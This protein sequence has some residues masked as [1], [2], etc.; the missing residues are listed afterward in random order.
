MPQALEKPEAVHFGLPLAS[1]NI[2]A[3]AMDA[4]KPVAAA[5]AKESGVRHHETPVRFRLRLDAQ[6]VIWFLSDCL[7]RQAQIRCRCFRI[8]GLRAIGRSAASQTVQSF[9]K[10]TRAVFYKGFAPAE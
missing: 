1:P 5:M 6:A 9:R 8:N 4:G 7:R 3:L 10:E 2:L